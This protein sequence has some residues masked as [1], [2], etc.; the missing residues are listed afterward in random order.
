MFHSKRAEKGGR[1]V[2]FFVFRHLLCDI[3]ERG[4]GSSDGKDRNAADEPQNVQINGCYDFRDKL[5]DRVI[6]VDETVHD[7]P[8]ELNINLWF[9]YAV[10][11]AFCRFSVDQVCLRVHGAVVERRLFDPGD[12]HL[13]CRKSDGLTVYMDR[14]QR[15]GHDP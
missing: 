6:G 5:H 8:P 3:K 1:D 9:P 14:G 7:L 12:K 2:S 11:S 10:G 13:N 15:R 4:C